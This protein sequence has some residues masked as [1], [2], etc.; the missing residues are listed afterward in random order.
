MELKI[1]VIVLL[2]AGACSDPAMESSSRI[3]AVGG[4][5]DV[6]TNRADTWT[7]LKAIL[8]D[9]G[10]TVEVR[11]FEV[12][13]G[14]DLPSEVV[15]K[16]KDGTKLDVTLSGDTKVSINEEMHAPPGTTPDATWWIKN[17]WW[18]KVLSRLTEK[19]GRR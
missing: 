12:T 13:A 3:K 2:C 11:G 5:I 1:C 14:R 16:H 17:A 18:G 15:A 6:R 9:A 4:S 19:V 10:F 7:A 8:E